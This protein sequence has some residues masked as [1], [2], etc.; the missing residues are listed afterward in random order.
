[1]KQFFHNNKGKE[2][3]SGSNPQKGNQIA[4][5]AKDH[6]VLTPD[7]KEATK[8]EDGQIIVLD[9]GGV[10][11]D[12]HQRRLG[13][14][15]SQTS[16]GSIVSLAGLPGNLPAF[17]AFLLPGLGFHGLLTLPGGMPE[18]AWTAL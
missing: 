3:G 9:L 4:V 5:S 13:L 16:P 1:M 12:G 17:L 2:D 7:V 14:G 8:V 6:S 10:T 18:V 15:Y 11:S